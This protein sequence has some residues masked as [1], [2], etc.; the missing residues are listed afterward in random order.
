MIALARDDAEPMALSED[1]S[2]AAQAARTVGRMMQPRAWEKQI[3][4]TVTAPLKPPRVAADPR[5]VRQILLK[6]ADNAVKFTE[7]GGVEIRVEPV[8]DKACRTMLRF[9]VTDTGLGFTPDVAD[10]IF[11]PFTPGD[12]LDARRNDGPGLGLA[13]AKRTVESLGGE[14][15][16]ESEKA[17]EGAT[18][19]LTR[20][21][22]ASGAR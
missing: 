19:W 13:V 8:K 1:D 22:A 16:F 20:L 2:D 17:G 15:G 4:F 6:L 11:E 9:S 21:A 14:I 3:T 18:F 12:M 5:R 10:H 7:R